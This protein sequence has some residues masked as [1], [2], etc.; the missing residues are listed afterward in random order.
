M[1]HDILQV[2]KYLLYEKLGVWRFLKLYTF[3]ALSDSHRSLSLHSAQ[4]SQNL[5]IFLLHF[6]EIC[7]LV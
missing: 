5:S 2:S 3:I 7:R 4:P 1:F 6:F